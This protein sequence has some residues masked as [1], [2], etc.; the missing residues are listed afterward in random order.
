MQTTHEV[1][2][3]KDIHIVSRHLYSRKHHFF[4]VF[5]YSHVP[6]MVQVKLLRLEY[7]IESK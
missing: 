1:D 5:S 6:T 2:G 7:V 4:I 3:R